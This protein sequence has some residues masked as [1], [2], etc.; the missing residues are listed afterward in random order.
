MEDSHLEIRFVDQCKVWEKICCIL[1]AMVVKQASHHGHGHASFV[2]L[3]KKETRQLTMM[4]MPPM[5]SNNVPMYP[6]NMMM[7]P[8][9][10]QQLDQGSLVPAASSRNTVKKVSLILLIV[11]GIA[12]GVYL[13]YSAKKKATAGALHPSSS[14][15]ATVPGPASALT[16]ASASTPTPTSAAP[17]PVPAGTW[18]TFAGQAMAGSQLLKVSIQVYS[19]TLGTLNMSITD[20]NDDM[21]VVYPKGAPS[22]ATTNPITVTGWFGRTYTLSWNA[23]N[24]NINVV[25]TPTSSD[26]SG[27]TFVLTKV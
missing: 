14:P 22:F 16:P 25:V 2:T 6:D 10:Q 8:Q 19:T 7:I 20:Q 23:T 24:K 26:Y 1:I 9:Q 4:P 21:P 18:D 17:A 12:T 5:Y 27:A 11:V 15:A 13:G 3:Q